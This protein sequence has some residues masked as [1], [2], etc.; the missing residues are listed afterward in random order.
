MHEGSLTATNEVDLRFTVLGSSRVQHF[1][2]GGGRT[3]V[4][5]AG[6]E[7]GKNACDR[8]QAPLT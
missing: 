2:I 6:S 4:A 7:S 5:L 1:Q 3:F 8:Y